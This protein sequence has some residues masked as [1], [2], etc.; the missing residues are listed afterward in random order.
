[1]TS[2]HLWAQVDP[3]LETYRMEDAQYAFSF[4]EPCQHLQERHQFLTETGFEVGW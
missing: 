3:F 4:R 1:M 2:T